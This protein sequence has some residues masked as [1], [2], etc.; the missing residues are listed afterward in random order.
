MFI[1]YNIIYI[2]IISSYAVS[3]ATLHPAGANKKCL[4]LQL[5]RHWKVHEEVGHLELCL[6]LAVLPNGQTARRE[7][8]AW[9]N[10]VN[11]WFYGEK[12]V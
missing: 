9:S 8:W 1:H 2:Y 4:V 5:Q 10:W 11:C 3:G 6:R 7:T 12:K